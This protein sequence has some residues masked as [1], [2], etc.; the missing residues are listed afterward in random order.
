MGL[1]FSVQAADK[2]AKRNVAQAAEVADAGYEKNVDVLGIRL[3]HSSFDDVRYAMQAP[4]KQIHTGDASESLTAVCYVSPPKEFGLRY[5]IQ[6]GS[7]EMGGGKIDQISIRRVRGLKENC[8]ESQLV[9]NAITP[10]QGVTIGQPL[11]DAIA[12]LKALGFEKSEYTGKGYLYFYFDAKKGDWDS[13]LT[14][15]LKIHGGKNPTQKI[16]GIEVIQTTTN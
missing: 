4:A 2:V 10:I 9:T 16:L 12:K 14:V 1:S 7:G 15:G 8:V 5:F 13:I 11:S 3:E 6:F